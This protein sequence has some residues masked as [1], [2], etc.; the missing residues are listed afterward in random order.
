MKINLQMKF[1]RANDRYLGGVCGGIAEWFKLNPKVVRVVWAVISLITF[2]F[3]GLIIYI[4]LWI[5]MEPP[6]E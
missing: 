6:D 4:V 2:F 3:P 1:K 5:I